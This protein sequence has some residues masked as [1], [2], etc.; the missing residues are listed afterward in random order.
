LRRCQPNLLVWIYLSWVV[1]L[2]AVIAAHVPTGLWPGAT[3]A[4]AGSFSC[5]GGVAAAG[6][7]QRRTRVSVP[8]NQLDHCRSTAQL[9]PVL[10]TLVTLDW[11]GK[12]GGPEPTPKPAT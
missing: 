1:L 4:T 5:P 3:T 2:G 9:E 11:V 7:R 8:A 12:L 6:A 10:E